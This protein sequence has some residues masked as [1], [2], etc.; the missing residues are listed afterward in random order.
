MGGASSVTGCLTNHPELMNT[1][2]KCMS[3]YKLVES[4]PEC[5]KREECPV[6]EECGTQ[7][8][9]NVNDPFRCPDNSDTIKAGFSP[10]DVY[11]YIPPNK[12]RRFT[13]EEDMFLWSHTRQ[14]SITTIG[15]CKHL[16]KGDDLPPYSD[17]ELEKLRVSIMGPP[18]GPN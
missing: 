3:T 5:P 12:A 9:A 11:M 16:I 2:E 8:S 18:P 7:V 15:T 13:S 14:P 6:C 1:K 4:C 10:T 17:E